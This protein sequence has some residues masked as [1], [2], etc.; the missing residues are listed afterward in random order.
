MENLRT[1]ICD[2]LKKMLINIGIVGI[3]AVVIGLIFRSFGISRVFLVASIIYMTIGIFSPMAKHDS[4]NST[5]FQHRRSITFQD[6]YEEPEDPRT[7]YERRIDPGDLG[8][9]I[10]MVS[11]GIIFML[12]G[13][14]VSA[15]GF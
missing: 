12:I 11:T 13:F 7:V 3:L 14:A 5:T 1:K 4:K 15:A 2:N 6:N 9:A 10:F 8:F